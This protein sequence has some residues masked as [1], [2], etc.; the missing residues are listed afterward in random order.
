M[1]QSEVACMLATKIQ[2]CNFQANVMDENHPRNLFKVHLKWCH[3][4]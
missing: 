2:N 3:N 1:C 4:D